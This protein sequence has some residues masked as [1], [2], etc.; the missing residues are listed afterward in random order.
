MF[1]YQVH[2]GFKLEL[3][4]LWRASVCVYIETEHAE[5]PG[6][7]LDTKFVTSTRRGHYWFVNMAKNTAIIVPLL[8]LVCIAA[9]QVS[10]ADEQVNVAAATHGITGALGAPGL[11]RRVAGITGLLNRNLADSKGSAE[12]TSTSN[13]VSGS[14]N[15][16]AE[17]YNPSMVY[18]KTIFFFLLF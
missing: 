4:S 15:W 18:K 9:M 10:S 3:T 12:T 1:A 17:G 13:K 16:R 2:P 7:K 6:K 14:N 11:V 8:V 5:S